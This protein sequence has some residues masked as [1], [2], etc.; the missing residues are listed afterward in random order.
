M[1]ALNNVEFHRRQRAVENFPRERR[2]FRRVR[3]RGR[4]FADR[5]QLA[6]MAAE[7]DRKKQ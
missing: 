5:T 4:T 6:A 7:L 1:G 3:A 2:L